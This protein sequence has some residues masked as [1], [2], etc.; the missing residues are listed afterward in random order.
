MVRGPE[1]QHV[2][3]LG[4]GMGFQELSK[5]RLQVALE[6][7]LLNRSMIWFQVFSKQS[8]HNQQENITV[9]V[10]LAQ[11][12]GFVDALEK[13]VACKLVGY[14]RD[15]HRLPECRLQSSQSR[16]LIANLQNTE[17][18]QLSTLEYIVHFSWE[19]GKPS[20]LSNIPTVWTFHGFCPSR[21][22]TTPRHTRLIFCTLHTTLDSTVQWSYMKLDHWFYYN[23]PGETLVRNSKTHGTSSNFNKPPTYVN[24]TRSFNIC[25]SNLHMS[26]TSCRTCRAIRREKGGDREW[27]ER[28]KMSEEESETKKLYKLHLP[29][30]QEVISFLLR[31]GESCI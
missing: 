5:L 26:K 12:C 1:Q 21:N 29:P 3:L 31:K 30:R 15:G 23:L 11:Y 16:K 17:S 8:M 4:S 7:N 19:T 24:C 6:S 2:G 14:Q 27:P 9:R 28:R 20:N 25:N 18:W 10:H 22:D 13:K